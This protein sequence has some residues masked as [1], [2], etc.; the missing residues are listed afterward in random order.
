MFKD[1]P[2]VVWIGI[3][4]GFLTGLITVITVTWNFYAENQRGDEILDLLKAIHAAQIMSTAEQNGQTL[5][6]GTILARQD[7]IQGRQAE[8]E[9]GQQD[10]TSELNARFSEIAVSLGTLIGRNACH[11]PAP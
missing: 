11:Q 8:I 3:V 4:F 1:H 7:Q 2:A 9:N 5:Q 10:V 6:L